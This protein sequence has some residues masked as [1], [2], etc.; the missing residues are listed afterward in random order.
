MA[1]KELKLS[2]NP[3]VPRLLSRRVLGALIAVALLF[4]A[5]AVTGLGSGSVA[6]SDGSCTNW[7]SR[8]VPPETIRVLRRSGK[9]EQV[10]FRRYVEVVMAS[11]WPDHLPRAALETAAVAVKQYGWSHA[12]A[13]R[14]KFTSNGRCYDVT[15]TTRHQLYKP[16]TRS[17][18]SNITRA[19]KSTW[20]ISVRK[21]GQ[22][23]QTGY[24]RGD[25]VACG[26]DAD[27]RKLY[28][29][30]VIDCARKGKSRVQIQAIYYGS[31]LTIHSGGGVVAS[32]AASQPAPKA[33]PKAT[34]KPTPKATPKPTPR[35]TPRPTPTPTPELTTEQALEALPE[36]IVP[37]AIPQAIAQS[38]THLDWYE[39]GMLMEPMSW[40]GPQYVGWGAWREWVIGP[41]FL[42]WP[43]EDYVGEFE[44]GQWSL[45]YQ[46]LAPSP[47]VSLPGGSEESRSG[48]RVA[49]RREPV[50]VTI[51]VYTG[52]GRLS[53]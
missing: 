42:E 10:G 44:S 17:P 24:R 14:G 47:P 21:G 2:P 35:P 53:A 23:F 9:I 49:N 38:T 19:V 13:G 12:L 50:L 7:S 31:D 33:T 27:G 45:P 46:P 43:E 25:N 48:G 6:A 37:I 29:R 39:P 5:A 41:E 11:E 32:K 16:E 1:Q 51:N 28:A 22:F 52:S 26:R 8:N 15:D 18:G 3:S 4:P 20:A 36:G 34:P 30:S 40:D